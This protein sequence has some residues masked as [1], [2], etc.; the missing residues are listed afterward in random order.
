MSLYF[1][2]PEIDAQLWKYKEKKGRDGFDI[3]NWIISKKDDKNYVLDASEISTG[4]LI[5]SKMRSAINQRF[6][7]IPFGDSDQCKIQADM[8]NMV[9]DFPGG[10]M[11]EGSKL[12]M[13]PADDDKLSQRFT[14][15]LC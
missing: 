5:T 15:I 9:F 12:I 13:M 1:V 6:K 10:N 4:R 7:A 11:D 8:H 14:L 3:G 2:Q